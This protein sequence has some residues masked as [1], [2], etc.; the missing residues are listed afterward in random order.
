MGLAYEGNT[1]LAFNTEEMNNY[2]SE[3]GKIADRLRVMAK[4]LDSSLQ[5]LET[6]G[7]TTGAG[8]AFQLMVHTNWSDNIEKYAKLLEMFEEALNQSAIEYD[9]LSN[10]IESIKLQ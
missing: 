4:D 10:D 2:A 6:T 7:W 1:N 3:Y 8:A 5:E 9:N